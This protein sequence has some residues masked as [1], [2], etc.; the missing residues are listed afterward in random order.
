MVKQ[1]RE[2]KNYNYSTLSIVKQSKLVH[3]FPMNARTPGKTNVQKLDQ[4]FKCQINY[5]MMKPFTQ[6][7]LNY[8]NFSNT[9]GTI[10]SGN[11][12]VE[13]RSYSHVQYLQ[14]KT[15]SQVQ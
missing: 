11:E 10:I 6:S 15:M 5:V 2:R 7:Y 9:E 8:S 12:L 13:G 4:M 1:Y 3:P 14:I